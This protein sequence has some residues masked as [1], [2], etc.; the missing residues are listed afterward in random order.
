[1]QAIENWNILLAWHSFDSEKFDRAESILKRFD[2]DFMEVSSARSAY[3]SL[4][5]DLAYRNGDN[6]SAIVWL[7]RLLSDEEATG[8]GDRLAELY[9]RLGVVLYAAG[10]VD[11]ALAI[12]SDSAQRYGRSGKLEKANH[13]KR[14]VALLQNQPLW[15]KTG[16]GRKLEAWK[17][18]LSGVERTLFIASSRAADAQALAVDPTTSEEQ[19]A[20]GTTAAVPETTALRGHH[21]PVWR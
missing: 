11:R 8:R 1:M 18:G 9:A 15:D 5:A 12:L 7:E 20:E 21:L 13:L 16:L 2:S 6:E 14:T 10:K 3:L 19:D 4:R 17:W